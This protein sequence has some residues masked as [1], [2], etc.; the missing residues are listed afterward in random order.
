MAQDRHLVQQLLLQ[1]L[2]WTAV[3]LGLVLGIPAQIVTLTLGHNREPIDFR[4]KVRVVHAE[5]LG[6]GRWAEVLGLLGSA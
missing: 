6:L 5:G 4:Q 1:V 2:E 3:A